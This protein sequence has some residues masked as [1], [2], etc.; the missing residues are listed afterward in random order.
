MIK[1]GL[2][3]Q[4]GMLIDPIQVSIAPFQELAVYV[5]YEIGR[6]T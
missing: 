2:V 4:Y 1:G 6:T 3:Q 5:I